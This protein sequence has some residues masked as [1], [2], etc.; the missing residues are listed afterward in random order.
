[1][2]LTI[3][4]LLVTMS[5]ATCLRTSPVRMGLA[6]SAS[7]LMGRLR[8]K[9]EV[10]DVSPLIQ[11]GDKLPSVEVMSAEGRPASLSQVVGSSSGY[12]LLVGMPGAFTPTCSTCHL[13]SLVEAAPKFKELG[14]KKIAVMTTNDRYVNEAWRKNIEKTMQAKVTLTMLS[15]ADGA[16]LRALGLVDDLGFGMGERSNRFAL[17]AGPWLRVEPMTRGDNLRARALAVVA[18]NGVVKHMAVDEGMNTLDA[19]SVDAVNKVLD[20]YQGVAIAPTGFS[21]GG[22][23]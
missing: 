3:T 15:D 8:A 4:L 12:S 2:R 9:R 1:M 10:K 7:K 13:P 21:W 6:S 14:V 19:S 17:L 5:C 16:A 22:T 18:E 20:Y 11:P 23:F